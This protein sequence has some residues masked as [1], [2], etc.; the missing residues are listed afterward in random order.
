ME[1][2]TQS[3]SLHE[4]KL[5]LATNAGTFYFSPEQIIRMESC[6]NYTN[7][8]FKDRRPILASKILKEF[9]EALVPFGFLRTHR[10]HLVNRRY[11]TYI[12]GDSILM[13]DMSKAEISRRRKM[14]VKK[15][16][17]N[18]MPE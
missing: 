3:S 6:S 1:I 16:L 4:Y 5:A 14:E 13:E 15:L 9:E 17:K 10:S 7:I 12:G 2:S 18:I 8:F 11:I